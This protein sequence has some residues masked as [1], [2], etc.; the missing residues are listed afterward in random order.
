MNGID[1]IIRKLLPYNMGIHLSKKKS[2]RRSF[3]R[4]LKLQDIL[5]QDVVD[6]K[7]LREFKKRLQRLMKGNP[8]QATEHK[9]MACASEIQ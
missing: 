6:T 9:N 8:S 1:K 3:S 4:L 2:E 5:P 7:C